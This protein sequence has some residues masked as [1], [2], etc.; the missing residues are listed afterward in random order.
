[1]S[2]SEFS[3]CCRH[4]FNHNPITLAG[5]FSETS[6]VFD[7]KTPGRHHLFEN[8]SQSFTG[9]GRAVEDGSR[10]EYGIDGVQGV[11]T[12]VPGAA[13]EKLDGNCD[14]NDCPD[15]NKDPATPSI[16][17]SGKPETPRFGAGRMGKIFSTTF[18]AT[19]DPVQCG[20]AA[21]KIRC[22]GGL[23]VMS[24]PPFRLLTPC[25]PHRTPVAYIPRPAGLSLP[26]YAYPVKSAHVQQSTPVCPALYRC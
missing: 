11:R 13:A 1:M 9:G 24:E 2:G 25:P 10:E 16:H 18:S 23:R 22:C 7:S 5:V 8:E 14:G 21:G 15:Q 6:S 19:P 20:P 17:M 26:P 3:S 4:H 12:R